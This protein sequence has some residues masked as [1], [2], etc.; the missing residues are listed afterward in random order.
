MHPSIHTR[1]SLERYC[2][3]LNHT[4]TTRRFSTP[5]AFLA[6]VR[7]LKYQETLLRSFPN[8]TLFMSS[9]GLVWPLEGN[10]SN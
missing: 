7:I 9:N 6:A 10:L 2:L 3:A 4:V 1:E 8:T 5:D